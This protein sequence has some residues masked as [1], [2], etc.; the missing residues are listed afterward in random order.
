MIGLFTK[1][2]LTLESEELTPHDDDWSLQEASLFGMT[3]TLTS[4]HLCI[5]M[6]SKAVD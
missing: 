6:G 1:G 4:A 5:Q 2:I 3:P